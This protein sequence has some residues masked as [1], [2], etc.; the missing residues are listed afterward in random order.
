MEVT[1]LMLT[2]ILKKLSDLNNVPTLVSIPKKRLRFSQSLEPDLEEQLVPQVKQLYDLLELRQQQRLLQVIRRTRRKNFREGWLNRLPY[3][4]A[5]KVE[6]EARV[7]FRNKEGK[8]RDSYSYASCL[9]QP[10]Y[11]PKD[12]KCLNCEPSP[13]KFYE[14]CL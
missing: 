12:V 2:E 14:V 7:S 6:W 13:Y 10:N 8:F 3:N 1:P 4:E 9:N 11:C 5:K